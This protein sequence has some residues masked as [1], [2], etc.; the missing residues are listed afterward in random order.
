[1]NDILDKILMQY[2][3][4][5]IRVYRHKE[6]QSKASGLLGNS[7]RCTVQVSDGIYELCL[8]IQD[9]WKYVEYGRQPG[10]FPPLDVIKQWIQIKPVI[11]DA[12]S[13][14][15]PTVE[16]LTYLISRSI[17][18]NGIPAKNYLGSTLE[19]IKQDPTLNESV[20]KNIESRVDLIFKD[21]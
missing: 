10:K 4:E 18:M 8:H 16:Q 17:A 9:Y 14:K 12:R 20:H 7:L 1:M 2:G 11:P 19:M 6:A 5:I 21:F 13:G 15:V 3:D